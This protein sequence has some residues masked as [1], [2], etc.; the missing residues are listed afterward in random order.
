MI[1]KTKTE[2]ESLFVYYEDQL[3]GKLHRDEELIYSFSYASEWIA[4]TNSFSLSLSLPLSNE[5]FGNRASLS[6]FENLL[7]EGEAREAIEKSQKVTGTFNFLKEFG[8]DCAGAITLSDS[9]HPPDQ[10]DITELQ[11]IPRDKLIQAIHEKRSVAEVIA[12]TGIGYL[13]LA[14]AQDKF[15]A[16]FHSESFYLPSA[17]SPTT[18]IVKVPIFRSGVS[19]SV[20]NE[21]Y[22]MQL[23]KIVG[24]NIPENQVFHIGDFP[25]FVINRYD[26]EIDAKGN[27]HRLH[28]QDFCQAHGETSEKKYESKGGPTIQD[29]FILIKQNVSIRSRTKAQFA[30]LDWIAFNFLV[31]NNDSHSKNISFLMK[32]K[33][34]ELAPFYDLLCTA[35]YP[36]LQREFAF[37]IG[38]RN[39]ASR[40]GKNQFEMLDKQLEIKKGTMSDRVHEMKESILS[41]KNILAKELKNEF[42]KAKV[43]SNISTN[44]EKRCKSLSKQGM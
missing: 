7:P 3:V 16:V 43:F 14:G 32:N 34:I 35:I 9:P 11:E 2:T 20:Y 28:Q 41:H 8:K 38:D 10:N 31:G 21:Y 15:A 25:L 36:K 42:P 37:M 22:C 24:F 27:V 12:E 17:G 40:I 5:M 29:N 33:K 6:F 18:H 39:D 4:A 1:A 13:P 44:I 19:E 30:F 26:R 23:A